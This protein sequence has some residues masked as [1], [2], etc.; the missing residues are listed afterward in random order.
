MC[1]RTGG[2]SSVGSNSVQE[3]SATPREPLV[4][5]ESRCP[6]LMAL[7]LGDLDHRTWLRFAAGHASDSSCR[8]RQPTSSPRSTRADPADDSI[9]TVAVW[10]RWRGWPV[11]LRAR[12]Q[13]LLLGLRPWWVWR[14]RRQPWR[15]PPGL[16]YRHAFHLGVIAAGSAAVVLCSRSWASREPPVPST[17]RHPYG[18]WRSPGGPQVSGSV[19]RT[20]R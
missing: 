20:Q 2:A 4:H 13:W 18:W 12:R 11:G 16:G 10:L 9:S 19:L 3:A 5:D 7:R 14:L 15:G 17:G 6:A 1:S 8:R